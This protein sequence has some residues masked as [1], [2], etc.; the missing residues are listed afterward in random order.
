MVERAATQRPDAYSSGIASR[1]PA[2]TVTLSSTL[3][4]TIASTTS[5]G[6]ACGRDLLRDRPER[7]ARLNRHRLET[8]RR[9][10][11]YSSEASA[12]VEPPM[13]AKV[14]ATIAGTAARVARARRPRLVSRSRVPTTTGAV[15]PVVV[16]PIDSWRPPGEKRFASAPRPGA[17]D[18]NLLPKLSSIEFDVKN[19]TGSPSIERDTRRPCR[20]PLRRPDTVSIEQA[21][22]GPPTFED[23]CPS[24]TPDRSRT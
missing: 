15:K 13:T 19:R 21:H 1:W 6:S 14:S 18:T 11:P 7:I 2:D 12:A 24:A 5:R 17:A 20:T 9:G 3:S 23:D 16:M 8:S 4:R 10:L 22:H